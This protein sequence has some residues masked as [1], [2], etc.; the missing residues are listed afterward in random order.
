MKKLFTAVRRSPARRAV[1]MTALALVL[2]I[3]GF[4]AF[5]R[6]VL[7]G[8]PS[9]NGLEE[10]TPSLTTRV[11]DANGKSIADFSIQRRALIPLSR[12]PV[13]LQNAVIATEDNDFFGHYGISPKGMLRSLFNDLLHRRAAQG[14]STVTQQLARQIFLTP[15]KKVIRKIREIIIAFQIERRFSKEE[16][17]QM[18]LNQI[19]FGE[20]AHGAGEAARVYFGK[21]VSQLTLPES[22][23]L[24]G[25]IQLPGKYSPFRNAPLAKWRRSIVLLRMQE[26]GYISKAEREAANN[27]PLP[28][29]KPLY[30]ATQAPYFAEYVRQYL[31]GK[32][33]VNMLYQGGL[34]VHTT[35]DL[36]AQRVAERIMEKN[37][38]AIDAD[39]A[40][41][42]DKAAG[43]GEFDA[44]AS[45]RA[46]RMQ[47]AFLMLDIKTGA[48]KVLIGGRDYKETQFNRA[49]QA[50]RQPGSTFKPF[51]WMT[52][53][54]N[55][56]TPATLVDD[57][58]MAYYYDG[59]DW[60]LFEGATDQYSIRLATQPFVGSKDFKI[61]VPN[62]FD[63]KTLG[64][65]TLRRGLELS[66]NLVSVNL[67]D[68]LGPT[69]VVETAR[70]A[71]VRK[72]LDPVPSLGLGTS[73]LPLIEMVN[74][75]A[76]FA[77]G[78]IRTEPF[79]VSRVEDQQGRVLEEHVP[80]ET[81]AFAPNYSFV[82]TNMMRGVVERGTAVR[83]RSLNRPIAGKTGTSQ[84]HRD[85]WFIGSTPDVTAG[86]WMG[87]DDSS[88]IES[89]DWTGGSIVVPWWTEIMG[90]L[91]K[92][93]P[94]RQFPVP[95][96]V[97][98]V[99]I[100]SASGKLALPTCPAKNKFLEAF[101]KGTEP[102]TFCD[103]DHDRGQ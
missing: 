22:A 42:A 88:T 34:K 25:L 56:Y 80:G 54:Q 58:P 92:D 24:A 47:G 101:V 73:A 94:A 50:N 59:R 63:Y 3:T 31:E 10:Y 103:I 87:Y 60:R 91:L 27:E 26:E 70:R 76:T 51:V 82:L 23:L 20:S 55:G 48:I 86:A 84:D 53:L 102:K 17:L 28:A 74:A 5:L 44:D 75:F 40:K 89:R 77:N 41:E 2:C 66:R 14:A 6:Y 72:K 85:M 11:F 79:A 29:V 99:L 64:K 39:V 13:D 97:S 18:Y 8:L 61:W 65:I 32:Y 36:D 69:L 81:E 93:Q 37:L 52:A 9:T 12:I 4:G 33:G 98:F 78:G 15:E 83:A 19:Y 43:N 67:V 90:E 95:E 21:D 100:D 7:S 49:M 30:A 68:K 46:L 35:L 38:Q 16:I 57:V 62:N 96:G 71:G 45:T 1:Y